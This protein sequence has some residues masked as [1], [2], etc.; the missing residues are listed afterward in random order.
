MSKGRILGAAIGDCVHVG[1]VV[2]FLH[3][4][5]QMGYEVKSL[6]PA[7]PVAELLDAVRE[8]DPDIVAVGYRLTPE[9]GREVLS[10]LKAEALVRGEA[11]LQSRRVANGD[12]SRKAAGASGGG[13]AGAVSTR[14]E[15]S[16]ARKGSPR[17][18]RWVLG[19][20]DPVADYARRLDFF[21][22]VFGGS[23]EFQEL[24]DFLKGVRSKREGGIPPQTLVD[25]ILWKRPFPILRHHFGQPTVEATVK[26]I[27]QI[28]EAGVLDVVSLGTDQNAQEHFFRPD[29][30]DP[31][32]HG[33]GGVPVRTPDDL[34]RLY[35]ATRTG[36]YPLMRCYSGTRDQLQ[37]AE[38]LHDTIHN[39]WCAI[40]LFWYSLL[41]G[42][43]QRPLLESIPEVQAVMRWHAERGVPVESNE[44]HHWS[45]RDAPD[46]VAVA[47]AYI[48]A[49]N[50]KKMGVRDYVQQ[51][52]WNNP[53]L[54]SPTM[55]LAKMLAKLELVESLMDGSFRVWRECRAGLTSM[56]AGFDK[57]KGHLA[58]STLIQMAVR[59]DIVHIV[60]HS[61]YHHAATAQDIIEGCHVVQGAIKL[62]LQGLPDMAADP[63]VQARKEELI[64]EAK[65]LLDAIRALAPSDVHDPL[66]HAPTLAKAVHIGLLDA[67]HLMGNKEGLG[68]VAVRFEDGACRAFDRETGRVLTE[69][70]RLA[71]ILPVGGAV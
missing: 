57:A 56:P 50:A 21:E 11:V 16:S 69:E 20:T 67:P 3:L 32:E 14:G 63:K 47:A 52:M 48:A 49:Y 65:L 64:R 46:Q 40:P 23:A 59:P 45:L 53:P 42:R 2:R 66:L 18:R 13:T 51:L 5:E 10:H 55:D 35:A 17:P 60:G 44:S 29:E 28:A 12:G 8:W 54:T 62:A 33:A 34:R 58:A 30:M 43:S 6:G 25:R 68:R 70:E 71:K 22:A 39:A 31:R 19:A 36:N 41:D 9:S 26:G 15:Q 7:V 27:R 37:W 61:E 24:V 38:M 4:A 1:G